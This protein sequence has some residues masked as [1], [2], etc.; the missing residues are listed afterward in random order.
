MASHPKGE[1]QSTEILRVIATEVPLSPRL[2]QPRKGQT[3][4][5]LLSRL[6]GKGIPWAQEGVVF[7]IVRGKKEGNDH[8]EDKHIEVGVDHK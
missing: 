3:T 6:E 1:F 8:L 2:Y 7:R 5:A 4:F